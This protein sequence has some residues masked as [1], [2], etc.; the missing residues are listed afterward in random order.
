MS[1]SV[2]SSISISNTTNHTNNYSYSSSGSS[3]NNTTIEQMPEKG[4]NIDD[5]G[6]YQFERER[7][8]ENWLAGRLISFTSAKN[9]KRLRKWLPFHFSQNMQLFTPSEPIVY[10]LLCV[11]VCARSRS[12]S[13]ISLLSSISLASCIPNIVNN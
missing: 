13:F 4:K 3:I 5:G 8:K 1:K 9:P 6:I 7:T 12:C 10:C 2:G 11:C